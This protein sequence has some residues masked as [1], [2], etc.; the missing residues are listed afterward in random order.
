MLPQSLLNKLPTVQKEDIY[1]Y[2]VIY[3]TSLGNTLQNN[4]RNYNEISFKK[5]RKNTILSI[6]L[7]ITLFA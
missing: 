4:T 7:I 1:I 3:G 2:P 5:I 6:L